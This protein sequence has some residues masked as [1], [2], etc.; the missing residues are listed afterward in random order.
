MEVVMQIIESTENGA[1]LSFTKD[2][3]ATLATVGLE[4]TQGA[5]TPS[6]EEWDTLAIGNRAEVA[7]LFDSLPL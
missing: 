6:D 3:L 1:T 4:F 5:Y 7:N 2:E